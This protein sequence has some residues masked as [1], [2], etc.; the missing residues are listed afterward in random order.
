[1][2]VSE[3]YSLCKS[4]VLKD[5]GRRC[6]GKSYV[7]AGKGHRGGYFALETVEEELLYVSG[8]RARLPASVRERF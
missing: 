3:L 1:M 2:C 8:T 6:S 7:L 5:E 4:H